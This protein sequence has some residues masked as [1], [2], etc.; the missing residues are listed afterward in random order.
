MS[1]FVK[2]QFYLFGFT[3]FIFS[4]TLDIGKYRLKRLRSKKEDLCGLL[5]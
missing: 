5:I 4:F 2:I 1:T 3:K